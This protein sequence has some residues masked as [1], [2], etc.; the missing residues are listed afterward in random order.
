MTITQATATAKTGLLGTIKP[1]ATRQTIGISK[2][3][4]SAVVNKALMVIPPLLRSFIRQASSQVKQ[5]CIFLK[6]KTSGLHNPLAR[7]SNSTY[8]MQMAP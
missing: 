3:E 2:D 8:Q 4:I 7:R 5:R 1:M 6:I